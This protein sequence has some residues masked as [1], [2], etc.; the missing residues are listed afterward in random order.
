LLLIL[1]LQFADE[2]SPYNK[3]KKE[4]GE[5]DGIHFGEG[6]GGAMPKYGRRRFGR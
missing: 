4:E 2:V 5:D 3:H 1:L 6:I